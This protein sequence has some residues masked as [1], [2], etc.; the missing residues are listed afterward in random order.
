[1]FAA[2]ASRNLRASAKPITT[3]LL[4]GEGWLAPASCATGVLSPK[5][6]RMATTCRRTSS[7]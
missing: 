2:A 3:S 7:I 1:M 5:A 6:A 4:Y